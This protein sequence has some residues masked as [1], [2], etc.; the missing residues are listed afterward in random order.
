MNLQRDY[1]EDL[2]SYLSDRG[3]ISIQDTGGDVIGVGVN[4]SG[5]IISKDIVFPKS[6]P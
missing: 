6:C 1:A 5:N 3:S 4:D 2:L